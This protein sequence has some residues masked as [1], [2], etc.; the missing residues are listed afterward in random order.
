MK[1]LLL[2]LLLV[3]CSGVKYNA[4]YLQHIQPKK[5]VHRPYHVVNKD[6]IENCVDRL[7][8]KSITASTAFSVCDG[9][10]RPV[11]GE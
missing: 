4:G 9:I 7:V 6:R 11:R 10:F 5:E 3:G 2:G 1:V 8:D